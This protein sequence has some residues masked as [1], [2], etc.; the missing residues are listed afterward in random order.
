MKKK[1]R[2]RERTIRAGGSIITPRWIIIFFFSPIKRWKCSVEFL[3]ETLELMQKQI[4]RTKKR[5]KKLL[6]DHTNTTINKEM[7]IGHSSLEIYYC[8]S[9]KS[10]KKMRIWKQKIFF[11]I[12]HDISKGY[13]IIR[14]KK[15]EQK[16][17]LIN[18]FALL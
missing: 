1:T 3:L 6:R 11:V 17:K 16:Q 14:K 12:N 9:R 4:L 18:V 13:D 5:K 2:E 8:S 10:E 7:H 15:L